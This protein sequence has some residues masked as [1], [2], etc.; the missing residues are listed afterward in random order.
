MPLTT[1]DFTANCEPSRASVRIVR[2]QELR[3]S[4]AQAPAGERY[5]RIKVVAVPFVE[6][7]CLIS[8]HKLDRAIDYV[9]ESFT[10]AC[11]YWSP[12]K[13]GDHNKRLHVLAFFLTEERPV[14][15]LLARLVECG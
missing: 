8:I 6:T 2:D 14:A 15:I 9:N 13:I 1:A 12:L 7:I 4:F 10:L 11:L 5:M 3:F